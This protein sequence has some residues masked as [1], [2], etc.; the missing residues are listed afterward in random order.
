MKQIELK[1]HKATTN[2]KQLLFRLL[3]YSLFEESATD[4][5]KMN[6]DGIFEYKWF[7]AYFSDTDRET[8]IFKDASTNDILGFAMVCTH[9]RLCDAGHSIAEFMVLPSFRRNKIGENAAVKILNT[10]AGFWEVKP[11]LGS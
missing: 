2:D 10:H 3:Q 5:N 4:G 1:L 6:K 8:Y 7:D 11:S 9:V